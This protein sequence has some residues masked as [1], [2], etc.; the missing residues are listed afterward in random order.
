MSRKPIS[1]FST[2]IEDKRREFMKLKRLLR[3]SFV[4]ISLG[5]V[6]ACGEK[7]D[8]AS[9]LQENS[10]VHIFGQ[11][12][13][14]KEPLPRL[15]I[16]QSVKVPVSVRNTSNFSWN[17]S[18][19]HPVRFAYH[20]FDKDGRKI[21]HDGERTFIAEDLPVEIGRASCRERV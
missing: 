10:T 8:T 2:V 20:W 13:S 5:A 6:T 11:E 17:A 7:K 16:S 14:L 4:L 15:V 12:I 21:V 18:G 3:M 9:N 1:S 19:D